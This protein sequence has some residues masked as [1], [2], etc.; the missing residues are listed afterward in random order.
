MTHNIIIISREQS[1]W[2]TEDTYVVE[3]G[4][5]DMESE[6]HRNSDEV[7]Y[8][9]LL[10]A[11]CMLAAGCGLPTVCQVFIVNCSSTSHKIQL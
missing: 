8:W 3:E 11:A 4:L 9:E 1:G 7:A 6:S 10:A 5:Q 2:E